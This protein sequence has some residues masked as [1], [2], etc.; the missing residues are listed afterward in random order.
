MRRSMLFVP[1]NAPKMMA[2]C[3]FFGADA[4]IFDLE[5]AVAPEEKDAARRLVHHALKALERNG[6]QAIVRINAV[7]SGC[8]KQ[9]LQEVVMPGLDAVMLPKS[10][11]PGALEAVDAC[12]TRL[13]RARNLPVGGIRLIALIETAQGVENAAL[14]AAASSRL[15]G[16]FLG[17]EDLTADLRCKRTREGRE[18]AY[19]R[20]RLVMTAHAA[21]LSAYDT[22]FTDVKDDEGAEADARTARA[23]GFDGKAAISPRHLAGINRAFSPSA[24][25]IAYAR[26]VLDAIAAGKRQGRGAVALH[27][28]MIDAPIVAR[29]GQT[30]AAAAEME[31]KGEAPV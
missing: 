27:G 14:L 24:E 30:L 4:I 31:K 11:G 3:G 15:E 1:G 12:M 18:I 23:F 20:S 26:E 22:P 6:C 19:A 8:W 17:A 16:L 28:K 29:A 7:D 10:G 25:E 2:N 5:D 13:E 21:G 9:D